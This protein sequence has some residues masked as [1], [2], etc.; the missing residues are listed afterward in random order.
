MVA[1][2][3]V[4]AEESVELI[5]SLAPPGRSQVGSSR[6]WRRDRSAVAR[7]GSVALVVCLASVALAVGLEECTY[8]L[9]YQRY[10]QQNDLEL[11]QYVSPPS[12]ESVNPDESPWLA[13]AISAVAV[14]QSL[15]VIV[16]V[17]A[18][19][20]AVA[21]ARAALA[22]KLFAGQALDGWPRAQAT[23]VS[24]I[25]ALAS[26]LILTTALPGLACTA[27]TFGLF[28]RVEPKVFWQEL[29]QA[30]AF[31]GPLAIEYLILAICP[32]VVGRWLD[33]VCPSIS[34]NRRGIR[35]VLG[36]AAVAGFVAAGLLVVFAVRAA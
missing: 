9:R 20:L 26:A 33:L 18:G 35:W 34:W 17:G 11:S 29:A 21:M 14:A 4:S 16:A 22:D 8:Q 24:A 6:P 25:A 13:P 12:H 23:L 31:T 32:N 27:I 3:K 36:L 2:G 30:A 5:E 28:G 15:S 19:L 7:R 10:R 1:E